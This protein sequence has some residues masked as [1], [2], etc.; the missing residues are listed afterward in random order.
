MRLGHG[1]VAG[2]VCERGCVNGVKECFKQFLWGTVSRLPAG[3]PIQFVG[4]GEDILV[5]VLLNGCTFGNESSEQTVVS[6]VL[7]P[8]G[9]T[10]AGIQRPLVLTNLFDRPRDEL[11]AGGNLERLAADHSVGFIDRLHKFWRVARAL[12][13]LLFR[14]GVPRL[15]S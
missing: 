10:T 15:S 14:A 1:W 4:S 6:L 11:L 12:P 7:R 8:F 9:I 13:L 3:V 2:G 5:S